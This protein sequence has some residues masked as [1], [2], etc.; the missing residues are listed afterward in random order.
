MLAVSEATKR[1]YASDVSK[2]KFRVVFPELGLSYDN[3]SIEAE[4]MKLTEAISNRDSV[5]YV[6]CIASS[7]FI[8]IYGITADVKNKQIELYIQAD[9][10]EEIPLFKGIVDSVVIESNTLFKAI[11]AYDAL[12]SK[13]NAD[14]VNWYETIFPDEDS[15]CTIKE[16]RDSL[17]EYIGIEQVEIALP[18]DHIVIKKE[19][20]PKSLK[21]INVLKSI[22]QLNGCCGIIGRD[23]KFD[24]RYIIMPVS[25]GLYPG[26]RTFPGPTT[27]PSGPN[28]VYT[29]DFYETMKFE[30]Y[31]VKPMKR[32]QIRDT[33]DDAGITV[34]SSSGNKYIIQANMLAV[35]LVDSVLKE[36]A[37]NILAKL[38][39]VKFHPYSSKNNGLPFVEVGDT[40][41]YYVSSSRSGTYATD[42]FI[43]LSRT[44][45]GAQVLKDSYNAYGNE[46][47]SEFVT[48]LQVTLDALKR[49]GGDADL[50]DYYTKEE[51]QDY[52]SDYTYGKDDV[53]GLI[54]DE[55]S[56]QVEGMETPTGF[57]V[58]SVYSL[59]AT[60]DSNTIYLIRGM[61]HVV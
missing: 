33:E 3:S 29:F 19:Y 9:N 16:I 22:C 60:R 12:Y 36:V 15:T 25:K 54:F 14:V 4:T 55:V 48:D 1:A 32:V 30:E 18:N 28:I 58:E 10:T 38:S 6:G 52:V 20:E 7:L 51:V 40:V 34:G 44:L 24:Y 41:K 50:S 23:G 59:P 61:V 26:P 5:E 17:C 2:K 27:F 37:T 56:R 31:F 47:Q 57:V 8:D 53:D 35:G 13:G 49:S 39:S 46:E 43:V 11:T 21:C 42:A 45:S